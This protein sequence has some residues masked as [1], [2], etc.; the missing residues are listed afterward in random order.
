MKPVVVGISDFRIA[1]KPQRLV[2]YG[3]GSCVAIAIYSRRDGV[4]GMA[5]IMLP[6]A[7]ERDQVLMPGKYADTAVEAIMEAFRERGIGQG[8]MEAKL[9]GGAEMFPRAVEGIG[10]RIGARNVLAAR[11]ILEDHD[12]RID[13]QDVGGNLGRTVEFHTET[14][15]MLVRTL[16]GG[17]KVI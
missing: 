7:F 11:S 12:V 5:H 6:L 14:W 16:R 13:G 9:A 10:T 2:T 3:L 17:M 4:A 8:D 15:E 1:R